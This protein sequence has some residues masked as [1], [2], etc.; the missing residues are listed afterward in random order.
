MTYENQDN[1]LGVDPRRV[2]DTV[3]RLYEAGYKDEVLAFCEENK[4][5]IWID[6]K[7]ASLVSHQAQ[8]VPETG[9]GEN[10]TSSSISGY[11]ECI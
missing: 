2:F 6:P 5:R 8:T 3:L 11:A 4:L 7:L 9:S 1:L 10:T